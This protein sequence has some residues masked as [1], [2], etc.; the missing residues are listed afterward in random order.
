MDDAV[1]QD[2]IMAVLRATDHAIEIPCNVMRDT[3]EEAFAAYNARQEVRD[4]IHAL[5]AL[6]IQPLS[7]FMEHRRLVDQLA[8]ACGVHE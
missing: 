3:L 2:A 4:A 8:R 5:M 7:V 6:N 1:V